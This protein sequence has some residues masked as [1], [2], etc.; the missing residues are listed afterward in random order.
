MCSL[1]GFR[2]RGLKGVQMLKG[3]AYTGG[4]QRCVNLDAQKQW[5]GLADGKDKPFSKAVMFLGCGYPP[6]PAQLGVRGQITM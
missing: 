2:R 6:W 3:R 1:A 5:T 4:F